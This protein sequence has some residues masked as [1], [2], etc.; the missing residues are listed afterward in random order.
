MGTLR[1]TADCRV[2]GPLTS[3]DAE[4]AAQEWAENTTQALADK[5]IEILKSFPMN[6]S[7]RGRGGFEGAL[8]TQRVSPTE[9]R[10]PGPTER[11][12]T[13]A[14]WL[15]GV[16]SRN[17]S[18]HFSGYKLFAKTRL[19]LQKLAPDIAQEEL[20]KVLPRMGGGGP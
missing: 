12:V 1:V 2:S 9:T 6:K 16:S 10:I 7:A 14:P 17:E 11:G 18:T 20:D 3:G 4:K 8:K 15:E 5:G 13:W 19:Q